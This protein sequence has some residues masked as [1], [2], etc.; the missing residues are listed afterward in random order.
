M[1]SRRPP[2]SSGHRDPTPGSRA[3]ARIAFGHEWSPEDA[4]LTAARAGIAPLGDQHWKVIAACRE[5]AA[6]T[7]GIPQLSRLEVL[8]GFGPAELQALF[9]GDAVTVIG[10]IA[11]LLPGTPTPRRRTGG[12]PHTE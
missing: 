11:G 9:P 6:R 10:R 5:E 8:T 7:G 2:G 4:T 12:R 3:H 1:S